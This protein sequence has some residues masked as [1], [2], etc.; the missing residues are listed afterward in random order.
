MAKG[1][2]FLGVLAF[3]ACLMTAATAPYA[4]DKPTQSDVQQVAVKAA[5]F[6]KDKGIDAAR[7]AFNAEGEFKHGEIYVNVINEQGIRLIYPPKPTAIDVDVLDAKDVD[8]KYIIKD[9]IDLAKT[10]KEGWTEY[11]WTNPETNKIAPKVTFV[12]AVPE[13]SAIVYVGVYK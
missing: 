12:M 11:R 9:I 10:K 8:G 2:L 13:R 7:D 6:L 4:A 5:A 1:K 3:A